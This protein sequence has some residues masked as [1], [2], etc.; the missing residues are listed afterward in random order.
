MRAEMY[1]KHIAGSASHAP[2]KAGEVSVA[3]TSA[4]ASVTE[5][6]VTAAAVTEAAVT[7]AAA[8][9]LSAQGKYKWGPLGE[10]T[11]NANHVTFR[12]V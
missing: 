8:T 7:E 5:A 4:V 12:R 1:A 11:A 3:D 6:E 2:P 9:S 10:F